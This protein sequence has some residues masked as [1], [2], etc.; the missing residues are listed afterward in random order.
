MKQQYSLS[1]LF[2]VLF[3]FLSVTGYTQITTIADGNVSNDYIPVSG[4][5]A[6]M[7]QHQQVIYPASMLSDLTGGA[8][9]S[10]TFYL[11]GLPA[12]SWNCTFTVRLGITGQQTRINYHCIIRRNKN[13]I[14]KKILP[15]YAQ[16]NCE[17]TIPRR[18]W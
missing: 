17:S 16:T 15:C 6:N 11:N 14:L 13:C 3:I 9:S 7:Q 1:W 18:S 8:I 12:A 5:F 4:R 2:S 10:M